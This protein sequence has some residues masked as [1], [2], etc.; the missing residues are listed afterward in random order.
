[1]LDQNVHALGIHEKLNALQQDT[2]TNIALYQ[3]QVST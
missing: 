1:M 3:N 2:T